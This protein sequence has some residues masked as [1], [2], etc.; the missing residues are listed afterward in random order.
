MKIIENSVRQ[1]ENHEIYVAFIANPLYLYTSEGRAG[2]DTAPTFY[3]RLH[4][5]EI[6]SIRVV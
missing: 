3:W 6:S 5:P 4:S 1:S 2:A